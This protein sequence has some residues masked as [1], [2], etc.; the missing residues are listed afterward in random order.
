MHNIFCIQRANLNNATNFLS[1]LLYLLM[2]IFCIAQEEYLSLSS[3]STYCLL[4][5][6]HMKNKLIFW[7]GQISNFQP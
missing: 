1:L 2:Y 6:V 7:N 5:F 3:T 4:D